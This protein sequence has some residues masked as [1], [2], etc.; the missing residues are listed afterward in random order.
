MP[1]PKHQSIGEVRAMSGVE[2]FQA[3]RLCLDGC[4][5]LYKMM[6]FSLVESAA[7]RASAAAATRQTESA[8]Q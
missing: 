6:R 2:R 1:I 7:R 8:E 4:A 3:I 5:E